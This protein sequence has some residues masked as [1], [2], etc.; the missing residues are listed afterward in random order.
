MPL[1]PAGPSI[2]GNP[3]TT[4]RGNTVKSLYLTI[5][6]AALAAAVAG[7]ALAG[8]SATTKKSL[9]FKASFSGT[10]TTQANDNIVAITANGT[11]TAT[12]LGAAKITGLGKGDTSQQPCVPFNG[13]GSMKGPGGTLTFTVNPS[14]RGCGDEAG[15]SFTVSGKLAMTKG[16]GKLKGF[17]GILKMSGS[18]ERSSGAFSVKF[19]GTLAK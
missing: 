17:K 15:Q 3:G 16:T 12:L 13:T 7:A 9:A 4:E 18:Y 5:A 10:A 8:T 2:R 14:S 1:D 11:G 19:F 6:S